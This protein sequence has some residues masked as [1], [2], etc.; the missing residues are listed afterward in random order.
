MNV[1]LEIAAMSNLRSLQ[2]RVNRS[3]KRRGFWGTLQRCAKEP[4]F[5]ISEWKPTRLRHRR[6][7]REFDRRFGVDTAGVIS[8]SALDVDNEHWE[9]GFSYEPT[10]S[11]RFKAVIGELP[12]RYEDF[13]FTDFGSGKGKAL[14][15]AAEFPF[16]K[17][18]GV[19]ISSR[20]H[21][22]AKQN[23][24]NYR[25]SSMKCNAMESICSD[26]TSF[27]ILDEQTVFYFFNPFQEPAM[28]RVLS[29]I[30]ESLRKHA[31]KIYIVYKAPLFGFLM[32]RAGFLKKIKSEQGYAVYTNAD[33]TE[34][35]D[36]VPSEERPLIGSTS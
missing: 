35:P 27:R 2:R 32:D 7:E 33:P 10:D 16:R 4:F 9:S 30:E 8:L 26:A 5:L 14:L 34:K 36:A 1:A 17:I 28:A 25:S 20:L 18:L 13:T 22:V 19:E 23:I 21:S 11:E 29:N 12:I 24:R 15:L 31:R 3:L 6:S